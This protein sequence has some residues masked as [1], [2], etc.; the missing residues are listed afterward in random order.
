MHYQI[1]KKLLMFVLNKKFPTIMIYTHQIQKAISMAIKAHHGQ[2][3]KGTETPYVTH[4]LSVGLIL[5]RAG[6]LEDVIIAGILHDTIEDGDITKEDIEKEF[7]ESIANI[8]NDV[9]EQDKSLPWMERKQQALEHV[10]EM[11]KDSLLVKS[12]DVLHNL[13]N[14]LSDYKET[15]DELFKRFNAPKEAQLTRYGKLIYALKDAWKDNPLLP[16]LES[17]YQETNRLWK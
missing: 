16:D 17:V 2:T 12:A 4:P 3:R 10:S 11:G 7:G 13:Q 15:G 9:T 8:V 1:S 6:A 14:T 5:A